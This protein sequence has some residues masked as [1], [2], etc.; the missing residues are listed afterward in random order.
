MALKVVG[1]SGSVNR[2]SRTTSLI[3]HILQA[4]EG[5]LGYQ[6][7]LIELAEEAPHLFRALTRARLE[8]RSAEIVRCVEGADLLIVGTPVYRASYTR[9]LKHLFDL[10]HHQYFAGKPVLLAATGGTP[11]HGLVTEHQLR[12]L[13]GFLNAL[14]LPTAIYA[15]EADFTD[16]NLTNATITSRINRAVVEAMTQLRLCSVSDTQQ[17][18]PRFPAAI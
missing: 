9:A 8:G 17:P 15:T 14:T 13:F 5:E 1:L 6:A 10:V 2:P 18:A 11:L 12:P 7:C 4:V 16:Y 3:R